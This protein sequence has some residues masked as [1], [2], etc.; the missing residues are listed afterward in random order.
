MTRLR[1]LRVVRH[2][3]VDVVAGFHFSRDVS[4]AIDPHHRRRPLERESLWVRV[5]AETG[6]RDFCY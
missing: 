4:A 1:W 5:L 3:D 6:K 2:V